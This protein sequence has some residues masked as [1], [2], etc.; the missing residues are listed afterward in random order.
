MDKRLAC[1]LL[2][3]NGDFSAPGRKMKAGEDGETTYGRRARQLHRRQEEVK[4]EFLK[5]HAL[6]S[7][8]TQ[9]GGSHIGER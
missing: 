9:Q 5:L 8:G 1:C 3:G 4:R 2:A 6:V 7:V